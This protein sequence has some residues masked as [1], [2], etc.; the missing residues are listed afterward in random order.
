[1]V[2][3]VIHAVRLLESIHVRKTARLNGAGLHGK[4]TNDVANHLEHHDRH[5]G[6]V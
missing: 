1:M 2:P 6:T 5:E 4:D 3:A